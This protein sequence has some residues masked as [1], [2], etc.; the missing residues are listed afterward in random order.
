[1]EINVNLNIT[2]TETPALIN[3]LSAFMA[4][5]QELHHTDFETA[6]A[7]KSDAEST[8]AQTP[9]L[10]PAQQQQLIPPAPMA[11]QPSLPVTPAP[12]SAAVPTAAPKQYTLAEIQAACAPLMD[13]GKTDQLSDVMKSMGV[14]SLMELPEAKYG[15]LAV[16]LRALGARL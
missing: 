13:A 7:P 6:F 14:N 8:A 12:Q 9:T 11:P 3:T 1:M 10:Q 2:L 5:L 4:A 15:E 16:K